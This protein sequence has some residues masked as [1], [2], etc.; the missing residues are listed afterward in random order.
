MYLKEIVTTGFKSFAD[1]LD[2]KLD[3]KITCIVGPNG[4]GKSNVVD[5]VRWVLGEQ[6][7]K[8]LR[9]DGSMSDVIFS[10]SKSRNPLNVASVELVFDNTDHY[11]NVP[12]T[13]ISIKR[14][15]YRTGENEYYLNGDKRRLKDVTNLV[16]DTGMG[17]ESFNIISQGEVEK[18]L[19][20]SPNDRRVIFEEA[21]GILKYK[22]RKEEALRKLDRTHNN[23][24]RVN[25][26]INELEIQVE[27][28]KEQSEKATEYLE[29]KKSLDNY[30]VALLAYD[31]ENYN[32]LCDEI[33]NNKKLDIDNVAVSLNYKEC[34]VRFNQKESND[35][36]D[37][38]MK[39]LKQM[40]IE[41]KKKY[42]H[43]EL[44]N[45]ASAL[46]GNPLVV[47]GTITG[48]VLKELIW[49]FN[50]VT[51]KGPWDLKVDSS[52]EKTIVSDKMPRFSYPGSSEYFFFQGQYIT[53]EELGNITYGYLGSVMLIPDFILYIGGGVAAH[54]GNFIQMLTH[55]LTHLNEY[56]PPYYGDSREDH[57]FV[58]FGINLYKSLH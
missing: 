18:I 25:D 10:G 47:G 6:S 54:G 44:I 32:R 31:I 14:K 58:E 51:H 48:N 34:I 16:L 9:G 35:Y 52:W 41:I 20:N 5:A 13:E 49:F 50:Q 28:L 38:I 55:A 11:I 24:D 8:S 29:N 33:A 17:K 27:P 56:K 43:D 7:V 45:I 4:S 22:R 12:Y 2:I 36:T 30:E 15:V 57:H 26:I 1:K 39:K 3:D 40:E 23:L 42:E 37:I 21:A 19:S 46:T 53:R